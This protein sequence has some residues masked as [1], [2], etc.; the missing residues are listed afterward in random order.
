MSK[1]RRFSSCTH[2]LFLFAYNISTYNGCVQIAEIILKTDD[3]YLRAV[4]LK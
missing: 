2:V 3:Q 1:S 4:N